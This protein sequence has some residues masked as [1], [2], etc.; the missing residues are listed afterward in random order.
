MFEQENDMWIRC[1]KDLKHIDSEQ[2][3]LDILDI[4]NKTL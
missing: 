2:T 3:P 4:I 1:S